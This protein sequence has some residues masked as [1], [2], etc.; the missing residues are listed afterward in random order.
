MEGGPQLS[1]NPK[2]NNMSLGVIPL[3]ININ[4]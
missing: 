4:H 3:F 1:E 2:L